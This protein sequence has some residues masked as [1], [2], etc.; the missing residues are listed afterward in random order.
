MD[1]QKPAQLLAGHQDW[2]ANLAM[3]QDESLLLS[4]DTKGQIVVWDRPAGK[5]LRRW[6]TKG[7]A[8]AVALR[9]DNQQAVVTERIPLIFDSGRMDAVRLYDL[10]T[11]QVQKDLTADFK[12]Q[13]IGSAAYSPDGKVLALAR[14]G[15]TDGT[16]RSISSIRRAA[17]RS[18]S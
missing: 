11:G 10:T 18:A 2:V 5:E 4:G 8:Y 1:I 3:S 14:G 16:A 9:P 15:E 12:G 13:H 6:K 7:W 17:R